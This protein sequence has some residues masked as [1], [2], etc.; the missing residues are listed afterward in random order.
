MFVRYFKQALQVAFSLYTDVNNSSYDCICV[1]CC[2]SHE[3]E[4]VGWLLFKGL[5]TENC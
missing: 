1:R 3:R 4:F 5:N 2:H